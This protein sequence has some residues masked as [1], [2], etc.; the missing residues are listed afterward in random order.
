MDVLVFFRNRPDRTI[1]SESIKNINEIEI[2]SEG[3][4][5][6]RQRWRRKIVVAYQKKNWIRAYDQSIERTDG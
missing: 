1:K 6:L 2:T 3:A 4:L 5:M